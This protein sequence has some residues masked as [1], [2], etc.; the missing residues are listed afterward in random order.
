MT[1]ETQTVVALTLR[2]PEEMLAH[3]DE[4]AWLKRMSRTAFMRESLNRNLAYSLDVES[5]AA[6]VPSVSE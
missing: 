6:L 5:K 3:L 2:I 1:T 4:A